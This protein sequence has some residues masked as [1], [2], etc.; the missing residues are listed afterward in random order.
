MLSTLVF[1]TDAPFAPRLVWCYARQALHAVR[2]CEVLVL[3][4]KAVHDC[5]GLGRHLNQSVL[6]EIRNA[7]ERHNATVFDVIANVFDRIARNVMKRPAIV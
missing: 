3:Q 6:T 4:T 2:V 1:A 5:D 7:I